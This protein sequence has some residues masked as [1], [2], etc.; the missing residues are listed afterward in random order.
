[1]AGRMRTAPATSGVL[2]PLGEFDP[3]QPGFQVFDPCTEI[4]EAQLKERKIERF[5]EPD[6]VESG[7]KGCSYKAFPE[8]T[9]FSIT[10]FREQ[11]DSKPELLV[12][13]KEKQEAGVV[14]S[15]GEV[16]SNSMC[17]A[18]ASTVR[19]VVTLTVSDFSSNIDQICYRANELFN[20]LI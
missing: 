5:G 4:S 6:F 15:R 9:E 10:A 20:E 1:M 3:A 11:V 19:G 8:G 17:R 18:S 2:P 7:H 14:I 16:F 13:I 12:Q